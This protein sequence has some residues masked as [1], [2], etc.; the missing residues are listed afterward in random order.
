M[1]N[2][3][4]DDYS[5]KTQENNMG[6]INPC[7]LWALQIHLKGFFLTEVY[8]TISLFDLSLSTSLQRA[9]VVHC[10]LTSTAS[11]KGASVESGK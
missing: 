6:F 9:Q 5:T 2:D 1:N 10:Q 8:K 7:L 4:G 3:N 11:C